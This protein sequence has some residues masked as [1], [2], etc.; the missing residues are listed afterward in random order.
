MTD[1]SMGQ[2]DCLYFGRFE[3]CNDRKVGYGG[4]YL[5]RCEAATLAGG[6]FGYSWFFMVE[7]LRGALSDGRGIIL[8]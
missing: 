2:W 6:G 4:N 3:A 8:R 5:F 7:R 1:L